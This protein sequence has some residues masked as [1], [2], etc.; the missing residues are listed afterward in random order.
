MK[1]SG[2][3]ITNP[4]A[5]S[6]A[7][8][9][10]RPALDCLPDGIFVCRQTGGDLQIEYANGA[11]S[12]LLGKP[13][14][15]PESLIRLLGTRLE[16]E[17]REV[18]LTGLK[19]GE[20]ISIVLRGSPTQPQRRLRLALR[21]L[22]DRAEWIGSLVSLQAPGESSNR[23]RPSDD[24]ESRVPLAFSDARS[25]LSQLSRT[26]PG[27]IYQIA[28]GPQFQT[29]YLYMSET[30]DEMFGFDAS[31]AKRDAAAFVSILNKEDR[32]R[33]QPR[34]E[35][36][37]SNFEPFEIEFRI[38]TPV[39]IRWIR[40]SAR[41]VR[42]EAG[43]TVYSAVAVDITELKDAASALEASQ[44]QLN[45]LTSTIPGVVF[46][47]AVTPRGD[48]SV[49][50]LSDGVEDIYGVT[51]A[52]LMGSADKVLSFVPGRDPV[53]LRERLVAMALKGETLEVERP[54]VS[55]LGES[56]WLRFNARPV[57]A[58]DGVVLY[59]GVVTDITPSKLAETR[60]AQSEQ[61]LELA[62][63]NGKL[64]LFDWYLPSGRIHYNRQFAEI[65]GT[66]LEELGHDIHTLTQYE[67]HGDLNRSRRAQKAHFA[68][69]T[70]EFSSE[71][72]IRRGDGEE[73][74]LHGRGRIVERDDHNQPVRY[75]GTVQDV[76]DRVTAERQLEQQL[77]FSRMITRL[78][79]EF[80]N[81][82]AQDVDRAIGEALALIGSFS[83][84]DLAYVTE[85]QAGTMSQRTSTWHAADQ[86][87]DNSPSLF[88]WSDVPWVRACLMNRETVHLAGLDALPDSAESDRRALD[89]AGVRE[90]VAL[91]LYIGEEALGALV[92]QSTSNQKHWS[93]G[94]LSLL[95]IVAEIISQA[96]DRKRSELALAE[97]EATVREVTRALPGIV[98]QLHRDTTGSLDWRFVSGTLIEQLKPARSHGR[99]ASLLDLV[100][101]R[102][103]TRLQ[104]TLS[105]SAAS[106]RH[107]E[108]DVRLGSG[109]R[110]AR[111]SAF[112][113]PLPEGGTLFNG[114]AIDITD[115]KLAEAAL[116]ASEERFR[117]LTTPPR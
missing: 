83:G 15:Q 39:G 57:A 10:S 35:Q 33:N 43:E 86:S 60:L 62:L 3:P 31:V 37:V 107:L 82:G 81:L 89:S 52:E 102:D 77:V 98:Y 14:F 11:F 51:A 117:E 116:H 49:T 21:P 23:A 90:L 85:A 8:A 65:F 93:P 38:R 13:A 75:V 95:R 101:P 103:L 2:Q 114:I 79:S 111:I 5:L 115:T 25:E 17:S 69:E 12:E 50:Y 99:A 58:E 68:G 96:L 106:Q 24:L 64:G 61:R 66:S 54:V 76:T 26:M 16:A 56:R 84:V 108:L 30:W 40:S 92:L 1:A 18:L 97:A 19:C 113:R 53:Q 71:Y 7:P 46:Q 91:P 87:G 63:E 67:F 104:A 80:V 59:N 36:A 112:P 110:W 44:R 109:M 45:E 74:W 72:R 100:D 105:K 9:L 28:F 4:Q 73:R 27:A 78:S 22:E 29:R 20:G 94:E 88:D 32:S 55:A 41:P 70:A 6:G 42:R 48:A 34:L 47:V